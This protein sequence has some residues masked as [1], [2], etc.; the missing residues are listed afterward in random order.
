MFPFKYSYA[1]VMKTDLY[2]MFLNL[3]VIMLGTLCS[4]NRKFCGLLSA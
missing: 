1:I 3:R 2:N 4:I